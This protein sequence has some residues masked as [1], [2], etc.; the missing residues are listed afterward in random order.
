MTATNL[1]GFENLPQT[2]PHFCLESLRRNNKPNAL[3]Y[4]A[5]NV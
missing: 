5:G 2:I 1:I 4:K 3:A